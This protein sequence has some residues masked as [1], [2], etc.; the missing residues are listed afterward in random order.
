MNAAGTLG[1]APEPRL[2]V[3]LGGLGAFVTNPVSLLPRTPASGARY[4]PFPGGFLL[5]T[6]HPNPGLET[7]LRRN[8]SRWERSPIPVFVHLLGQSV[9]ELASMALRLEEIS[10]VM[11]VEIGFPK[12]A[13]RELVRAF[14]QAACGELPVI[15]RLPFDQV[16]ALAPAALAA[17]A[18]AISLG[19]PRGV[20]PLPNGHLI[21]GRL[22]GPALFPQALGI[23][24]SL[25]QVGFPV[26]GAGGVYSSAQ[27]Q[28]MLAAGALAVQLDAVLWR[29]SRLLLRDAVNIPPT[30]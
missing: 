23:V 26:I 12:D 10:C 21:E 1:F 22:Y 19:A 11:G 27:A 25:A 6:G 14:I 15:A 29:G 3:D 17:G 16:E 7:V 30:Q 2:H 18:V 9:D 13:E 24:R 20:L 8:V 5:H 4:L 28:S